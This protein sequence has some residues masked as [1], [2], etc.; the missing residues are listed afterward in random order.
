[1]VRDVCEAHIPHAV[2]YAFSTENWQRLS[3]EIQV[4][5]EIFM[6]TLKHPQGVRVQV[7]GERKRFSKELKV[8]IEKVEKETA[9]IKST[10]IWIALSYGGR[11]EILTA[12]NRAIVGGK[13]IMVADFSKYLWSA[14]MPDP[15]LIIRTGGEMR[16]SNFLPWQ[17]VY[18]EL[19]YVY[20][21]LLACFYKS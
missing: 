15:D 11:Q 20:S 14:S 18:S 7:I 17:S 5:M 10:T 9:D 8:A 13:A 3:E 1:M 19:A 21:Y 4:L 16:L 6:E 12:V 2:F